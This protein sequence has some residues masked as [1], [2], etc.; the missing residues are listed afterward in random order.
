[1]SYIS[2]SSDNENSLDYENPEKIHDIYDEITNLYPEY[3]KYVSNKS[4]DTKEMYITDFD[5]IYFDG[6]N[7]TVKQMEKQLEVEKQGLKLLSTILT[8]CKAWDACIGNNN[9]F[10]VFSIKP[11]SHY[12]CL[13]NKF[14][15]RRAYKNDDE[16]YNKFPDRKTIRD[17]IRRYCNC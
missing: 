5:T 16:Y 9:E 2:D 13:K 6:D 17:C 15:D 1:M 14:P 7:Y 11:E 4:F 8:Q 12:M 10:K 3:S